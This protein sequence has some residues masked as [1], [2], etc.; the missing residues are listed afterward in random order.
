MDNET[1]LEKISEL[2]K[3]LEQQKHSEKISR[4]LIIANAFAVGCLAI[5][6]WISRHQR[7][8]HHELKEKID[9]KERES[10]TGRQ[11]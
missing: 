3:L 8:N 6:D 5:G 4:R 2:K 10:P 1:L 11:I 7:K 9:R